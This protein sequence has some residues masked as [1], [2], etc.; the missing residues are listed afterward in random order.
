MATIRHKLSLIRNA[1]SILAFLIMCGVCQ[2]AGATVDSGAED[3]NPYTQEK[4][5]MVLDK[6]SYVAG[7]TIRF[8]AF[9]LNA[10]TE[11]ELKN[12]SRYIYAELID[13][14]G[15]T[16]A[17]V[18]IKSKDGAFVGIIPLDAELPESIYTLCAYTLFSQNIP[19]DYYYRRPVAIASRRSSKYRPD[20][21]VENGTLTA[22]IMNRASGMAVNCGNIKIVGPD[23]RTIKE[24]R[25]KSS[26]AVKKPDFPTV[27]ILFD[28]YGKFIA[29]PG[30]DD[31][32]SIDFYPEGG[33]IIAGES[34]AIA[35]K[36]A[37][38]FGRP[39]G[40]E[41]HIEDSD[42]NTAA[43]LQS[44][45]SGLGLFHLV[46]CDGLEYFAVVGERRFQLPQA[47]YDKAALKIISSGKD[48]ILVDVIGL[49]P[50]NCTLSIDLRSDVQAV[51]K[52]ASFPVAIYGKSLGSGLLRFALLDNE[53]KTLSSR[54]VYNPASAEASGDSSVTTLNG[55]VFARD[56]D[57]KLPNI[58]SLLL[59]Q[60]I[61]GYVDSLPRYFSGPNHYRELDALMLTVK[62]DRYTD[63]RLDYPVELGAEISGIIKSRWRGK[64]MDGAK[65]NIIAPSIGFAGEARTDAEGRFT[66]DGID[67]PDGT[68]FV[69]Q[70]I[71]PNGNKEHNFSIAQDSFPKISPIPLR[72]VAED[73]AA[74]DDCLARLAEGSILLREVEI[75]ASVGESDARSL[76]LSAMG[77]KSI[78]KEYF[79][80]HKVT[81]Y[82]EALHAFPSL[83]IKNGRIVSMK[84]R[85]SIFGGE[86]EVEI[87]VDGIPWSASFLNN[88][89][90]DR[91]SKPIDDTEK[92]Y[93]DRTAKT[94]MIMTG[95]LLPEDVATKQ[96]A[97]QL[98][99]ISELSG[100]YPFSNV[101]SIE[102]VPSHSAV[103]ISSTAAHEG[104]ALIIT[105]KS[106]ADNDWTEDLFLQVHRLLGYQAE[107][108]A[109][110]ARES[111]DMLWIPV[112]AEPS[113]SA[114]PLKSHTKW[115]CG[116]TPAGDL[117]LLQLQ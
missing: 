49:R 81:T 39:L 13:P 27:K 33:A 78:A 36:S 35:F 21:S 24:V 87:W 17:R 65:I 62:S 20:Y 45:D 108:S 74:F 61:N 51:S 96:Y 83:R 46:P 58:K 114:T 18:K 32:L 31:E 101:K 117:R 91:H 52:P 1:I 90:D 19:S 86:P 68:A 37:D 11:K 56:A 26:I 38:S 5:I 30:D 7:D 100:S 9:L 93:S 94:A 8:R 57:R 43:K 112:A 115:V 80:E 110:S 55:A 84:G 15:N 73:D 77:V 40:V 28:N 42:G 29:L 12:F 22:R 54:L 92:Q 113:D 14:F 103:F 2:A 47:Q 63:Y 85:S 3:V 102:Y 116:F 64:P 89:P 76:M 67:W 109:F 23:G 60:D 105:T 72:Y 88:S 66:V 50:D 99:V 34:N 79:E 104:G 16:A 75:K 69:C 70:A 10:A 59:G 95:G 82:E 25:N 106:G 41:G 6:E 97:L 4:I 44:D 111:G 53:G 98:S 71:G 107:P 48:K